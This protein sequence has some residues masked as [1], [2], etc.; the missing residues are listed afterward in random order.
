MKP[1]SSKSETARQGVFNLNSA[2]E[3]EC[4]EGKPQRDN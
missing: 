1:E 2:V 4:R 3:A